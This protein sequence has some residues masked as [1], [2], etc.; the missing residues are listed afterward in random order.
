MNI[1]SF[2]NWSIPNKLMAINLLVVVLALSIAS[3][4]FMILESEGNRERLVQELTAQAKIIAYN[5]SASIEFDDQ[6]GA[7]DILTALET[8]P[9][10]ERGAVFDNKRDLFVEYSNHPVTGRLPASPYIFENKLVWPKNRDYQVIFD[11]GRVHLV[12]PIH[13]FGE[14]VGSI[15]LQ[16][17]LKAYHEYRKR[18]G[19]IVGGVL[20]FSLLVAIVIMFRIQRVISDPILYLSRAIQQVSE[21]KTYSVRASKIAEDEL[22]LLTDGFNNMLSEIEQREEALHKYQEKL[23]NEVE[24][25]T[26]D[27]KSANRELEDTVVALKQANRAIRQSEEH[28]R[29]A[30][31]S[32]KAKSQFLAN[33]SHELRTPM[34]G[35]LG[36]LSLVRDTTLDREQCHYIDV[37][38]QSGATLL[39]LLNDILDLSKIE[40][41]KLTL[42]II[43]FDINATIEEVFSLLGE[44][45]YSKDVELVCYQKS[46][47]PD[48]VLGDPVR[49]KQIVFNILGNAIKFTSKGYVRLT[50]EVTAVEG[51]SIE[52]R[53]EITDTGIGIKKEAISIIFDNFSQADNST[54]RKYGGTGLGLSLCEQL[55]RL[56]GG[57]IGVESEYGKGSTFWFTARFQVSQAGVDPDLTKIPALDMKHVLVVDDQTV[58]VIALGQLLERMGV[59]YESL[60]GKQALMYRLAESKQLLPDAM[61][62]D[63]G[64]ADFDLEAL[65]SELSQ[66]EPYRDIPIILMGS[67]AQRNELAFRGT[68]KDTERFLLKPFRRQ[69]VFEVLARLE[70]RFDV[71]QALGPQSVPVETDEAF[72]NQ[73][74]MLESR[75]SAGSGGHKK[76]DD[77]EKGDGGESSDGRIQDKSVAPG[78]R[79]LVV[80]DNKVNQQVAN[81][82][83]IK[84]GYQVDV[85]DN[86]AIALEILSDKQYDLILM[87]CHMPVLD[88]YETTKKLREMEKEKNI[89]EP[90]TIIAMTANVMEGDRQRC[91]DAGMDDYI[92]KP[93]RR[94]DL[95]TTLKKWLG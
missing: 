44:S 27:L 18:L 61:L 36:M 20:F 56:M 24:S 30:E 51:N 62:I 65:M 6:E 29:V 41:G 9:V 13:L 76:P 75:G 90:C 89:N 28:K 57:E 46:P 14:K 5:I 48:S 31:E 64:K 55:S 67:I 77:G 54:T 23:E 59:E 68:L 16:G 33:M 84:L 42:E 45:C 1:G 74:L 79:L 88:G 49:F 69:S 50:C 12:H 83:L 95:N 63:V 7:R 87:D 91:I 2:R 58:S 71:L 93:I 72:A 86:G 21:K 26:V 15:Y 60:S 66:K 47:I 35:V 37:A 22:G 3:I 19:V 81:G 85:A 38:Y 25:R 78:R 80:E 39:N 70:G 43:E 94:N 10:V 32:A 40:E 4:A 11:Q 8:V 53:F 34:N 17:D 52:M 73:A 82:H 92:A